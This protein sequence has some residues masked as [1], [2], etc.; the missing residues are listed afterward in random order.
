MTLPPRSI[1][2]RATLYSTQLNNN[3]PLSVSILFSLLSSLLVCP[4][5]TT[6]CA[7]KFRR[8]RRRRRVK[9]RSIVFRLFGSSRLVASCYHMES[10]SGCRRRR[11]RYIL[12]F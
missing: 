5:G 8:R 1:P 12:L 7:T 3:S 11:R 2:L 10:K 9:Q 6:N 4:R